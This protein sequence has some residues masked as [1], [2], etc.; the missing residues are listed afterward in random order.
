[1]DKK[2]AAIK[3]KE[4]AESEKTNRSATENAAQDSVEKRAPAFSPNIIGA[5]AD[6]VSKTL[7]NRLPGI[8]PRVRRKKSKKTKKTRRTTKVFI[9]QHTPYK[10]YK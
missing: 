4:P 3:S 1:M 6:E 2:E 10:F 8:R 9:F 7:M 5:I